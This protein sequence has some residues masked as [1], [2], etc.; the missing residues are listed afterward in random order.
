[1]AAIGCAGC[2]AHNLGGREVMVA[3]VIRMMKCNLTGPNLRTQYCFYVQNI[4]LNLLKEAECH[5]A[6]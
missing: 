2:G 1:M 3:C 5:N 6:C 4:A